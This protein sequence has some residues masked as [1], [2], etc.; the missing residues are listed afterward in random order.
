MVNLTLCIKINRNCHLYLTIFF[1]AFQTTSECTEN[2]EPLPE[3][4][5]TEEGDDPTPVTSKKRGHKSSESQ[6]E[7]QA[8][9]QENVS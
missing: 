9:T 1:C 7:V 4:R 2:A 8:E 5:I 6:D 3:L